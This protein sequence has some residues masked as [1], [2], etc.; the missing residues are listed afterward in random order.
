MLAPST[1]TASSS[2][3][4]KSLL[5]VEPLECRRM[6][7]V[8]GLDV[9][10]YSDS[11]LSE[12]IAGDGDPILETFVVQPGQDIFA[13]IT[14]EDFIPSPLDP[15][16]AGL[17]LDVFWNRDELGNDA[18]DFM[19]VSDPPSNF[20]DPLPLGSPALTA[21]LPESRR[22]VLDVPQSRVD[23]LGG[24]IALGG[25]PIG[26]GAAETFSRIG[27][28]LSGFG[29]AST[30]LTVGLNYSDFADGTSMDSEDL[31]PHSIRI[32]MNEPPLAVDHVET[33]D[34]DAAWPLSGNVL[35][36]CSDPD[37]SNLLLLVDGF[38]NPSVSGAAVDIDT[39]GDYTY[40][41]TAD[42]I[43]DWQHLA[44]GESLSDTFTYDIRDEDGGHATGTVTVVIEGRNDAPAAVG[45]DRE[46]TEDELIVIDVLSNDTDVD[47]GHVLS[48][49][50]FDPLSRHLATI[51]RDPANPNALIYNPL[52]K[53]HY[54]AAGN[55]AYAPGASDL[56][57][58]KPLG[59]ATFDTFRYTVKDEWLATS[60]ATV[61]VKVNGLNDPRIVAVKWDDLNKNQVPETFESVL[62]DWSIFIDLN[63][64]DVWD[65]TSEPEGKTD[66][67]GQF[68]FEYLLPGEY[69]IHEIFP[70]VSPENRWAQTTPGVLDTL[71][72]PGGLKP[73]VFN[74][75][76]DDV[77]ETR[78]GN[79]QSLH[80]TA[81]SILQNDVVPAGDLTYVVIFNRNLARQ[82]WSDPTQ[83]GNY[84]QLDSLILGQGLPLGDYI[85]SVTLASSGDQD[86]ST[87]T[88]RFANLP[89][90]SYT[91]T[92]KSE[93]DGFVD[94]FGNKLD[95]ERHTVSTVP[96]GNALDGG[97]FRLHF[98]ADLHAT[99]YPLEF[100]A[101]AP[102]GSLIY[103]P[104]TGQSRGHGYRIDP[105][106]G[107][108]L[109]YI[110]PAPAPYAY[111]PAVV[112]PADDTDSFVVALDRNQT[113]TVV[114]EPFEARYTDSHDPYIAFH[115]LSPTVE[116]RDPG[117]TLMPTQPT[118]GIHPQRL[119]QT[120][121]IDVAGEYTIIVGGIDNTLGAYRLRV[122]L[123]AAVEEESLGRGGN[124]ERALA[125]DIDPSFIRLFDQVLA[126][127]STGEIVED[128]FAAVPFIRPE[129]VSDPYS[130]NTQSPRNHAIMDGILYYAASDTG[131]TNGAEL[132]SYDG[133]THSM[134]ADINP[135]A[136][137][138]YPSHFA[139]WEQE[140]YFSAY[141]SAHGY[142]LWKFDGD[143]ATR[144]ADINPGKASSNPTYLT[145]Y[146]D[147]LYFSANDGTHGSELWRY[148]SAGA[149]IVEDI[150]PGKFG[151]LPGPMTEFKG[152][153]Y[154]SANAGAHDEPHNEEIYGAELYVFDGN[155]ATMVRDIN[156][157]MP[158]SN[159]QDIV[160]F[161]GQ[162]FFRANDG[163]H[164]WEAF[165]YDGPGY[166][167]VMLA[168]LN[169][170]SGG[171]WPGYFTVFRNRLFVVADIEG[172]GWQLLQY[173]G[174]GFNPA[175]GTGPGTIV[176]PDSPTVAGQYIFF[177]AE[178]ELHGRELWAY[179]GFELFLV[180]DHTPGAASTIDNS[181]PYRGFAVLG[182]ELFFRRFDWNGP[183]RYVPPTA[184]SEYRETSSTRG[185]VLGHLGHSGDVDWYSFTLD[186]GQT[187][188]VALESQQPNW[189]L[190]L[191]IYHGPNQLAV[192]ASG[193]DNL[194]WI[195]EN[196]LDETTDAA[197]D[198]YYV[199]VSG[200]LIGTAYRLLVTRDAT[201]D[202][203]RNDDAPNDT[204]DRAQALPPAGVALG[205]LQAGEVDY[206]KFHAL[207][208]DVILVE[209]S[210]PADGPNAFVNT[211]DPTIALLDPETGH[212]NEY[213]NNSP[214]GRNAWTRLRALSDGTYTVRISSAAGTRGE[215]VLNV[216]LNPHNDPK[217]LYVTATATTGGGETALDGSSS[218]AVYDLDDDGRVGLGDLAILA[219]VYRQ[220]VGDGSRELVSRCDFDGSGMV[221]LGDLAFFAANYRKDLSSEAVAT[222]QPLDA[223]LLR[224]LVVEAVAR[225]AV[226]TG[227]SADEIVGGVSISIV[228][229]PGSLI[230]RTVGRSIEIDPTAAGHG[231]FVD[232]TP[233]DDVEFGWIVAVAE[234]SGSWGSEA[235]AGVDLLSAVMHELGHVLGLESWQEHDLMNVSLPLGTR[236]LLD[237]AWVEE[238]T[239]GSRLAPELLDKLFAEIGQG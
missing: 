35:L 83:W 25:T 204:I 238:P 165:R 227:I 85:G 38:Q 224:P 148:T 99:N 72:T 68:T 92:L 111:D 1:R 2:A 219:S 137:G 146:N 7:T 18:G 191:E 44:V 88:L 50:S 70:D 112:I 26:I 226:A 158:H 34:E 150:N 84:F 97:D 214:D 213:E 96:S 106:D 3:V 37:G 98:V 229:L 61:T 237:A 221:D 101:V 133:V 75:V 139:V 103:T 49:L 87:L 159:V 190:S 22:G 153:L 180:E 51:T 54:D 45:D 174:D 169:S 82:D 79:R 211:L 124:G 216:R 126:I 56:L 66:D 199:G 231:W 17:N 108:A 67:N 228:D 116:L 4:G 215:Y 76:L 206:Y 145:V 114:V 163:T 197:P 201:F 13:R 149:M 208:G 125:Q 119:I 62:K 117:G 19:R 144:L 178:S 81:S 192:A 142:E 203:E 167:P 212:W 156:P 52:G 74:V 134:V 123:N 166:D 60:T 222:P 105:A 12:P 71:S 194:D 57:Q 27:F 113:I 173:D 10:L 24:N 36:G 233:G 127:P 77:R 236:R 176:L 128:A 53:Y 23:F 135:G 131:G 198:T 140:L 47:N 65:S 234:R 89:D 40:T 5:R 39:A 195:V 189:A 147:R 8:L 121:A 185:A 78:F 80:V 29:V 239:D 94:N 95:G 196:I 138:S 154:F 168:D 210:T 188:T 193:A 230:G 31:V 181:S 14:A 162:M 175:P 118:T 183:L 43:A 86:P 42:M 160:V 32:L 59:E 30:V 120:A 152:N 11:A 129:A 73:D 100:A 202:A 207:R 187:A 93:P 21:A 104:L 170:A 172:G 218:F 58:E 184:T 217:P 205:N 28:E 6:L 155:A 179:D 110:G 33:T 90:D 161:E 9:E 20:G 220:S 223:E 143:T 55:I 225:M 48:L 69:T 16:I 209:T 182:E 177:S 157:G 132:W 171:S 107:T 41:P 235:A 200:I 15:G 102:L 46:T 141:D 164:G 232:S 63:H 109:G 122:I 136:V 130:I 186:D 115:E 151:S 64:D 91:L